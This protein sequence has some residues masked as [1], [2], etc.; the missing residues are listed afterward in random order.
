MIDTSSPLFPEGWTKTV[1][2][3]TNKKYIH[4]KTTYTQGNLGVSLM[5]NGAFLV[6]NETESW[7]WYVRP[8]SRTPGIGRGLWYINS[9]EYGYEGEVIKM[10]GPTKKV[11]AIQRTVELMLDGRLVPDG[12][13][14]QREL[15]V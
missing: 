9:H 15:N 7:Q 14:Q 1:T 2:T 4:K 3:V 12:L 8:A 5:D 10:R 6:W 11:D 13:G